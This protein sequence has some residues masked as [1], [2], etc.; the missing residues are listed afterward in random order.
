MG[1]LFHSSYTLN[2]PYSPTSSIY[3]PSTL[4]HSTNTPLSTSSSNSSLYWKHKYH[5]TDLT[6]SLCP[7]SIWIHYLSYSLLSHSESDTVPMDCLFSTIESGSPIDCLFL[8]Y[9]YHSI[10][11]TIPYNLQMS[12]SL[13]LDQISLS[14]LI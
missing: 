2:H 9:S 12:L 14:F 4:T 10:H 13:S 8:V 6:N 11:R 1:T 7:L 5:W 3:W